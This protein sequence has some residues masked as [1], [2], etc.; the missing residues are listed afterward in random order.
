MQP[1]DK[2]SLTYFETFKAGLALLAVALCGGLRRARREP[3]W[4]ETTEIALPIADL[5]PGW[6]GARVVFLTDI[7]ARQAEGPGR[8]ERIVAA[9]D[10]AAGDLIV[11][12]GDTGVR[13]SVP[14]YLV[15]GLS[16]L[17]APLGVWAVL[18]NHD[19]PEPERMISLYEAAGIET[20]INQH[21]VLTRN[22][23]RLC[24][25][26]L[27]DR[28][29]GRPDPAGAMDGIDA[30]VPRLA[31]SHNPDCA[32]EIPDGVR[33]DAMLSGH[34]HAG[35]VRLWRWGPAAV[36][37]VNRAYT[38]GMADGPGFPVYVSRGLGTCGMTVRF[39]CAPEVAVFT[40]MPKTPR[41]G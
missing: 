36:P 34:T 31:I 6:A 18:G 28:R 26:G 21:R 29:K 25:A 9:A 23:D 16:G 39:H 32:D 13:G 5:P 8:L 37:V 3:Q 35:Q 14:D 30:G 20:L 40:L 12:G 27:D 2:T 11:I 22:G 41:D 19:Y 4:L 38:G 10:A 1:E 7:H 17:S 24:L 33:A 15:D